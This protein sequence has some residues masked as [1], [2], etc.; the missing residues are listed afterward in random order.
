MQTIC[1]GQRQTKMSLKT[2]D[3]GCWSRL[4]SV[5]RGKSSKERTGSSRKRSDQSAL[6]SL[7]NQYDRQLDGY[8]TAEQLREMFN[9]LRC[10]DDL[11]GTSL[12]LA[13]AEASIAACCAT[14]S[15]E[16]SELTYCIEELDR[17]LEI[18]RNARWEFEFL[19]T[20]GR[21]LISE[22]QAR[23]LFQ[24]THNER[25][26]QHQFD[27]FV[28]GRPRQGS[29]ISFEEIELE[30]CNVPTLHA[31]LKEQEDAVKKDQGW[32]LLGLAIAL[33]LSRSRNHRHGFLLDLIHN[34]QSST[35]SPV[36]V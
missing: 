27:T 22:E 33:L 6:R 28:R 18:V 15:C 16:L 32:Q 30:L 21:G 8:M 4:P 14:D 19:D 9:S 23:F 13:Q 7:F 20:V 11:S 2:D 36:H 1:P 31:V 17:R 12:S 25:F 10:L 35:Q 29:A 24:A 3:V 34:Q 5:N 26:S